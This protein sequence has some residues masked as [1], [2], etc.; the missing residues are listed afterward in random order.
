MSRLWSR[1]I[2]NERPFC[3]PLGCAP[4]QNYTL[5][6][7]DGRQSYKVKKRDYIRRQICATFSH[8]PQSDARWPPP[9][10]EQHFYANQSARGKP[11]SNAMQNIMA[12]SR[13]KASQRIKAKFCQSAAQMQRV[14]RPAGP[15]STL[16]WR[17][18]TFYTRST[19][20]M[21]K[22]LLPSLAC[23]LDRVLALCSRHRCVHMSATCV[24]PS[25]GSREIKR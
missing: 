15:L 1:S 25:R 2:G 11:A 13:A 20:G 3:I 21:H 7:N 8:M 24:G 4:M 10:I 14:G 18:E 5:T 16:D 22:F 6:T 19:K 9:C 17:H 12:P 23:K